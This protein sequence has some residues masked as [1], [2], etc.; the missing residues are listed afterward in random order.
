[1]LGSQR[2]GDDAWPLRP[3]TFGAYVVVDD[4]DALHDRAV[5]AGA[6]IVQAPHDT[7]YGSREFQAKDPEGNR[8]SF[9]SYRGEPV[10][11]SGRWRCTV[12]LRVDASAPPRTGVGLGYTRWRKARALELGAAVVQRMC[13]CPTAPNVPNSTA[14]QAVAA[15]TKSAR[16]GVSRGAG[17]ARDMTLDSAPLAL[18]YE[19]PACSTDA[20]ATEMGLIHLNAGDLVGAYRHLSR[21]PSRVTP[22]LSSISSTS[23]SGRRCRTGVDVERPR[24]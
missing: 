3:G 19:D 22:M 2:E 8:W 24:H 1:M 4:P 10:G 16:G 6:E 14:V 15:K 13:G 17:A 5:A 21:W 11:V 23:A 7:D 20:C 12:G 18:R 9:G